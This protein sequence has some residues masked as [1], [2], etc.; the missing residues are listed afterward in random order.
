MMFIPRRSQ[1]RRGPRRRLAVAIA[2]VA[3]FGGAFSSVIRRTARGFPR[4]PG[5]SD[6]PA[7]PWALGGLAAA[8]VVGVV[9]LVIV[10]SRD[11][12][13]SHGAHPDRDDSAASTRHPRP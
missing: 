3:A 6:W 1:L 5:G 11:G 2:T 9:L 8:A 13:D 12:D 7:P 4:S 10:R